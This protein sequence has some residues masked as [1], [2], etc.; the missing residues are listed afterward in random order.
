[1]FGDVQGSAQ[2][3]MGLNVDPA[4]ATGFAAASVTD[5]I[6][7][8]AY[9]PYGARRGTEDLDI[10]RGW[11]GQVEDTDTGLTYFNARYYDPVLSRF[12][13]PDPLMNPG[14]PRTLD[15][16]RY[17]E[18]NP[19]SYTDASGLRSTCAS[20]ARDEM[21]CAGSKKN[22]DTVDFHTGSTKVVHSH[23]KSNRSSGGGGSGPGG[24]DAIRD[25]LGGLPLDDG[26][27][28]PTDGADVIYNFA[29]GIGPDTY[30]FDAGDQFTK[31]LQKNSWY[32][33]GLSDALMTSGGAN[34]RAGD[35]FRLTYRLTEE[36]RF[37]RVFKDYF[38]METGQRDKD[39]WIVLGSHSSD[40]LILDVR[41]DSYEVL[42]R[43]DEMV[44][45]ESAT[46]EPIS[47]RGLWPTHENGPLGTVHIYSWWTTEIPR[48]TGNVTILAPALGPVEHV[49]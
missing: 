11:L 15:A 2:V 24:G 13:S 1:M 36:A 6:Q 29:Y 8:T 9:T 10:D 26:Y 31:D 7:R 32:T 20:N 12:L 42:I 39:A 4:S 37:F 14:D 40:V 46:Q 41:A 28:D 27:S 38:Q 33:A 23:A 5:T 30:Y 35:R 3:V 16:Y 22:N 44:T 45:S 25:M 17:A 49:V 19:I 48:E 21:S 18:N 43:V 34:W 47:R